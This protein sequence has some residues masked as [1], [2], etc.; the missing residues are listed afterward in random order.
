MD[1]TEVRY[2]AVRRAPILHA[3]RSKFP[4]PSPGR[5]GSAVVTV[6][7]GL[8]FPPPEYRYLGSYHHSP[9]SAAR[10]GSAVACQGALTG[11]KQSF[12]FKWF[13]QIGDN[14][15]LLG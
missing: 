12:L 7:L 2:L 10:L 9:P 15:G 13:A 6:V 11:L 8:L 14:A 5:R 3:S 4:L 1:R